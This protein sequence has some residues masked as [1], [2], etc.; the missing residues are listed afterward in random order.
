MKRSVCVGTHEE[1]YS[2]LN[3]NSGAEVSYIIKLFP[4]L[5]NWIFHINLCGKERETR[6]F[7]A[8]YLK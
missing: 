2:C 5:F 3:K 7:N 6:G 1:Q 4:G 8:L